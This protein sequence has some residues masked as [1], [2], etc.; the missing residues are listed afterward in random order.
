MLHTHLT[1]THTYTHTHACLH[2]HTHILTQI[3]QFKLSYLHTHI[4]TVTLTHTL[5]FT[6]LLT[7]THLLS[8]TLD[9]LTFTHVHLLLPMHTR[10]HVTYDAGVWEAVP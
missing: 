7:Y 6:S 2:S 1:L 8:G 4:I 3:P 9:P 5:T 10:T